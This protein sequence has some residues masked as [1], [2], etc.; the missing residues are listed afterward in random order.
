MP[1][2]GRLLTDQSKKTSRLSVAGVALA[3]AVLAGSACPSKSKGGALGV[4]NRYVHGTVLAVQGVVGSQV[5]TVQRDLEGAG[6]A[7][8]DE[9]VVCLVP[10]GGAYDSVGVT[11]RDHKTRVLWVQNTTRQFLPPT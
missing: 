8:D 11:L 1:S 10:D 4:C 3:I 7:L 9:L 2:P 5:P 6:Y